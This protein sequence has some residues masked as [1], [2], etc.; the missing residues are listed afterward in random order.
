MISHPDRRGLM[1]LSLLAA[2]ALS[3]GSAARAN[4]AALPGNGD[5]LHD[6]DIFMGSW[7][8]RHRRLKDRLAGSTEWVEFDGTSVMQPVLGGAGNMDD[9]IFNM[10]GGAYRGVSLRAYDPKAKTWAIWWLDERFPHTIEAPVIGGFK[11]GIGT[12]LAP[13][14][15]KGKPIIVRFLWSKITANSRQWEQAFSPDEGKTWE[16]NWYTY[17]TRTG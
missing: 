4:T 8:A 12:F 2:G 10:P 6:F 7:T 17:F 3:L 14:T 13:D 16:T 15:F 11:D 5:P 1:Q 9:N